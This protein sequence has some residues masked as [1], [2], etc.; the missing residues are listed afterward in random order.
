MTGNNKPDLFT[1]RSLDVIA[2]VGD[3]GT[4]ARAEVLARTDDVDR[5]QR[6]PYRHVASLERLQV[7][8]RSGL[9]LILQNARHVIIERV[10]VG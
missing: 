2:L 3:D 1:N 10:E 8:M 5:L 6:L 7:G 9:D 4:D